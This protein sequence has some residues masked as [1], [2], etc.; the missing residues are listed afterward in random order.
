M[1]FQDYGLYPWR[2][3]LGNVLFALEA[4]R[5]KKNEATEKAKEYIELVG[6][7]KFTENF[8]YQLSGGMKQRVVI[9]RTLAVEPGVL[10]LDELSE[11][12]EVSRRLTQGS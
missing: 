9:A 10:F 1:I 8:P 7:T 5:L 2:A 4:K 6:L 11:Q 12:T 3:V